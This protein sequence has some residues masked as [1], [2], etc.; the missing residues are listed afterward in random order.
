[1]NRTHLH[2]SMKFTVLLFYFIVVLLRQTKCTSV[3]SKE[4]IGIVQLLQNNS[5]NMKLYDGELYTPTVSDYMNCSMS[6][7]NCFAKEINVFIIETDQ[8]GHGASLPTV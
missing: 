1:M 4:T 6:T 3:C 2:C 7:L 8:K 5:S